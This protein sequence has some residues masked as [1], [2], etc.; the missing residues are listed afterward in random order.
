MEDGVGVSGCLDSST[1]EAT[2][3]HCSELKLG[4]LRLEKQHGALIG[5]CE[6]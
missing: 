5:N 2:G 3:N 1:A 6:M 4:M